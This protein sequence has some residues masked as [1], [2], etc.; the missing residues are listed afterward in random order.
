MTCAAQ[1]LYNTFEKREFLDHLPSIRQKALKSHTIQTGFRERGI[2]PL[3]PELVIDALDKHCVP[4]PDIEIW[5]GGRDAT[6]KSH[7]PPPTPSS[8][9]SSPKTIQKLRHHVNKVQEA[10]AKLEGGNKDGEFTPK[11][12]KHIGKV[13]SG[14]LTQAERGAQFEHHLDGINQSAKRQN[15]PRSRRQVQSLSNDGILTVRDANRHIQARKE[16]EE[17]KASRQAAKRTSSRPTKSRPM[18]ENM[19]S[20]ESAVTGEIDSLFNVFEM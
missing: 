15:K 5:D 1:Q 11:L 12:K 17:K 8:D 9:A 19:V 18:D 7:T 10:L 16:G 2:Y 14:G 6:G 13:F 3:K 4:I 20:S